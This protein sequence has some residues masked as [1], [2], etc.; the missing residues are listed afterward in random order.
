MNGWYVSHITV[1]QTTFI[2]TL[3]ALSFQVA[4][5]SGLFSMAGVGFFMLGGYTAANLALGGNGALV[6][7]GVP[8]IGSAVL[9]YGMS[10]VLRRLRGIYL[11]MVTVSFALILGV[12]AANGGDLTGGPFGLFGVPA[13][14][15][16]PVMV[17]SVLVA[18]LLISQ[19]ERGSAGRNLEVLR[20]DENLALAT[21][22]EVM[23][24]RH[25]NFALSTALGGLAGA[26][27]ALS[28]SGINPSTGGFHLV[29]LGLT[30]TVLGGVRTWSGPIVGAI[31]VTWFSEVVGDSV[32]EWRNAVYGL[33]ILV[34]VVKAPDGIV[35]LVRQAWQ[36]ARRRGS[37]PA[38]TP[39]VVETATEA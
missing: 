31:I 12:I 37:A 13:I 2:Y 10:L 21:G 22:Q 8:L 18:V 14:A 4:L 26:L 25:F 35:G 30:M 17:V 24:Q 19:L 3:V 1:I 33:V 32:G 28:F 20:L 34:I 7:I 38:A 36:W 27:Y 23:R 15:G 11:A 5:R 16:T 9:G 39:P 6:S 29:V